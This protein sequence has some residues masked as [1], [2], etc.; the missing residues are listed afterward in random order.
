MELHQLQQFCAGE[1]DNMYD[2]TSP[3][4]VAGYTYATDGA[5]MVRVPR[6]EGA[7]PTNPLVG[8]PYFDWKT[9]DRYDPEQASPLP[10]SMPRP[11]SIPCAACQ[12]TGLMWRCDF[13]GYAIYNGH[14]FCDYCE[15]IQN[16]PRTTTCLDCHGNKV[17]NDYPQEIFILDDVPFIL[18]RLNALRELPDLQVMVFWQERMLLGEFTGGR[19]VLMGVTDMW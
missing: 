10:A 19:V 1:P 2:L 9:F 14:D 11:A 13:C 8:C 17:I 4:S 16:P 6:V 15:S 5:V 12:G 7:R 3:F 18:H